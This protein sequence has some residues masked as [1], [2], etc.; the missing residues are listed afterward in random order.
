MQEVA[1]GSAHA[2]VADAQKT[3][4]LETPLLLGPDIRGPGLSC[5]GL[6]FN[7]WALDGK[8]RVGW[9]WDKVLYDGRAGTDFK[10]EQVTQGTEQ[11]VLLEDMGS[12]S[13]LWR[14]A[15]KRKQIKRGSV[16]FQDPPLISSFPPFL[17]FCCPQQ[18]ST[19]FFPSSLI[20]LYPFSTHVYSGVSLITGLMVVL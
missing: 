16:G 17:Y 4:H 8:E 10:P 11:V 15:K 9:S 2:E 18:P 5:R 12:V 7:G 3:A 13:C 6:G 14:T 19:V 1:W 20:L